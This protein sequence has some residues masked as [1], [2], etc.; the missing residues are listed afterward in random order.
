MHEVLMT[1]AWPGRARWMSRPALIELLACLIF[2]WWVPSQASADAPKGL[3]LTLETYADDAT[4]R[5][6]RVMADLNEI[7]ET[8]VGRG[9][10]S[11]S[12]SIAYLAPLVGDLR[13]GG[14]ARYLSNYRYLADDAEEDDEGVL[15]GRLFE[16]FGRAEYL[17]GLFDDFA[18]VPAVEFGLPLLFA[19]G[20]LQEELDGLQTQGF[21]VSSL[22]RM[23]FLVGAELGGRYQLENWLA[24]RAGL[25]LLHEQFWLYD[26]SVDTNLLDAERSRTISLMRFRFGIG[27]EANF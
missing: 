12:L 26:A 8:E 23:G 14:G 18:L 13:I 1:V 11:G 9:P 27:A 3:V 4:E 25:A 21:N 10:V 2:A 6:E 20:E 24:L 17:I 19:S 5:V 15:L 22:P 7:E 16:V